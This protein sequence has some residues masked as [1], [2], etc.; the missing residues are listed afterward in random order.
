MYI[1]RILYPVEVLGPGKRVGIWVSGCPH[2][3]KGCA[4]PELW[5]QDESRNISIEKI[6]G[7]LSRILQTEP[8]DGFT[9]TGGEP[10]Y[11]H[12]DLAQLLSALSVYSDDIIV[13]SGYYREQIEKFTSLNNIAVLIDGPYI[14]ARNRGLTLRGSDNQSI[15]ILNEKYRSLYERY[16][17]ENTS[18][19]I[20]NFI[21]RESVI[22]V[23]IHRPN[24]RGKVKEKMEALGIIEGGNIDESVHS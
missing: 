12:E 6:L 16:F 9:I 11:Q 3:C 20:Q 8:V 14:E 18:S 22:S 13:F 4:N 1:A 15:Y 21:E 5:G 2:H 19:S 7:L 24:F 10:F 23:G 17:Q